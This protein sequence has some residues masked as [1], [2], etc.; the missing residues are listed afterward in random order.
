MVYCFE[1]HQIG[2]LLNSKRIKIALNIYIYILLIQA[3]KA[4]VQAEINKVLRDSDV[5]Y[6]H[7]VARFENNLAR[8]SRKQKE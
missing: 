1:N 6:R 2:Y 8:V 5:E 4:L 7:L 3:L